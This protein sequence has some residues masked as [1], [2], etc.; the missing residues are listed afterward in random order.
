MFNFFKKSKT[1][2]DI[3][4]LGIDIH[5]HILPGIDDGAKEIEQS[6]HY[7][8]SMQELG[9]DKLYFTPHIFT[10][11][12]PNTKDTIL[13]A[14]KE[15]HAQLP[16]ENSTMVGGAAAEYMIDYS[17]KVEDDLLTLPG[18]Y[19][20]IEMSYLSETPNIEQVIF[21]LQIKGYHI[22]L[23]HPERYNF[24]HK[25]LERYVRLKE[26]GCIFQL[27][28]LSVVGYYGKEVKN[29][30]DYLLAKKLYDVAGTDLHHDKHLSL[31][32]N[33][34]R[35]GQLY[36]QIGNYEFQNKALFG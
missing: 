12:Y 23:A 34:V 35:N 5:S 27:N 20:L 6:I 30:A 14:L 28:L 31:L 15:V 13:P 26:M 9:F 18:N 8:K 19:L 7:I 10:E 32:T 21:D 29:A 33:V 11:L 22:V 24:Y 3:S 36:N 2:S 25:T 4:W 16:D 1:V 17:F